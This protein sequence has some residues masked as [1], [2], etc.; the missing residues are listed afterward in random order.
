MGLPLDEVRRLAEHATASDPTDPSPWVLLAGQYTVTPDTAQSLLDD[1]RKR[2]PLDED[3]ARSYA[4]VMR[5][6]EWRGDSELT[7][8]MDGRLNDGQHRCR[9]VVLSGRPINFELSIITI[10][11]DEFYVKID[12][13]RNLF[14]SMGIDLTPFEGIDPDALNAHIRSLSLY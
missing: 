1:H 6:G 11:M 12:A 13:L 3:L 8:T 7:I 14:I 2:R 4:R 5:A 9:A 10:D